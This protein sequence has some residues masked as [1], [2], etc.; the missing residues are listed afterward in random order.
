L[1][2]ISSSFCCGYFGDGVSELFTQAV[3]EPQA[4]WPQLP[5]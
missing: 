2:Q 4:S 5:K 1:S 3:H